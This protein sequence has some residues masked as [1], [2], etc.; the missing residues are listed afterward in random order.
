M[1]YDMLGR[2]GR[3]NHPTAQ[4]FHPEIKMEF[5]KVGVTASELPPAAHELSAQEPIH[6]RLQRE[7]KKW[8]IPGF[9]RPDPTQIRRRLIG[10]QTS[11]NANE[12]YQMYCTDGG[13]RLATTV[14]GLSWKCIAQP[15]IDKGLMEKS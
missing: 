15:V 2:S 7:V 12:L 10:P 13:Q 11:R 8:E 4:H 1:L 5:A 6:A 9:S 14:R 3:A